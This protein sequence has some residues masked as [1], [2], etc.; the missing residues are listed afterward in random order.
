MLK[1]RRRSW[2]N[3]TWRS[4]ASRKRRAVGRPTSLTRVDIS[5]ADSPFSLCSAR[6]MT[7]YRL[8][9]SCT[10]D[11]DLDTGL[12]GSWS[13]LNLTPAFSRRP[14]AAADTARWADHGS[15]PWL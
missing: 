11:D 5:Y 13:T 1:R 14:A 4:S 6:L 15:A 10:Q 12:V 8:W 9:L 7:E 2:P 3:L